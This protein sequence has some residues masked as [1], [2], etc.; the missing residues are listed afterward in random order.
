MLPT[1]WQI[2]WQFR[3][4]K[5]ADKYRKSRSFCKEVTLWGGPSLSERGTG[6]SPLIR[7]AG[8]EEK[9]RSKNSGLATFDQ[10]VSPRI[11]Q[12]ADRAGAFRN[13][14]QPLPDP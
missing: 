2:F 1:D 13:H 11:Q 10:R 12:R 6:R 9:H 5:E 4:R 3:F 14:P 8:Q 7:F